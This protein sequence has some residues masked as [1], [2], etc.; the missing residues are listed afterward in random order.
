MNKK[1]KNI[2]SVIQSVAKNLGGTQWMPS[3]SLT[4]LHMTKSTLYSVL[5]TLCTVLF[6]AS[7]TDESLVD[8]P[9]AQNALRTVSVNLG[10]PADKPAFG[11]GTT[12]R[13]ALDA[14]TVEILLGDSTLAV[15][16]TSSDTYYTTSNWEDGDWL[17][18]KIEAG[19][20]QGR[21]TL[22]YHDSEERPT[23]GWHLLKYCSYFKYKG[24]TYYG[25]NDDE[26]PQGVLPIL[27][28]TESE[29]DA[30]LIDTSNPL[31]IHLDW[32]ATAPTVSLIYINPESMTWDDT[33]KLIYY[34]GATEA[35]ELWI[36]DG[37]AWT[38]PQARLRVNTGAEGDVVTLTSS[39]FDSAWE[40][41]PTVG[42]GEN[43]KTV[44]TATTDDQGNAY[45]YGAT[46]GQLT[47]D[48]LVEL[49]QMCVP[50]QTPSGSQTGGE[51]ESVSEG[52]SIE[53]DKY[54]KEFFTITLDTPITLLEASDVVPVKL[55]AT[56]AYKLMA[57][58]DKRTASVQANLSVIDGTC[59]LDDYAS[60]KTV[61][62]CKEAIKAQIE[63]AMAMGITEFTVVNQLSVWGE[64]GYNAY[65]ADVI[66]SLV[67]LDGD[68]NPTENTNVG[69]ISLVF[70]D[71]TS[72][73]G[74][75]FYA[76]H[77][78]KNVSFSKGVTINNKYNYGGT[79]A[80]SYCSA[81]ENV[82]F[83]ENSSIGIC[84][85]YSCNQLTNI[86]LNMVTSIA[87]DAF[88][89]CTFTGTVT[90]SE[91]TEV[92]DDAFYNAT[93]LNLVLPADQIANVSAYDG[94]LYWAGAEWK[95]IKVGETEYTAVGN[96]LYPVVN[97]VPVKVIGSTNYAVIDGSVGGKTEGTDDDV[98][99][100]KTQIQTA[101]GLTPK[102]DHFL[103]INGLA[104]YDDPNPVTKTIVGRA[105]RD[106]GAAEGSIILVLDETITS[107]P[108]YAFIDCE[109][110]Q[111]VTTAAT[112][113]G[114]Y[115]FNDCTSLASV[116]VPNA[117]SIG[118]NAFGYCSSLTSVSVPVA[119]TIS[120]NAFCECTSLT[121]VE[122]P[123]ATTI[124]ANAFK[125]CSLL[126]NVNLAAAETIGAEAFLSCSSLA[127]ISLPAATTIMGGAFYGC[128]S[129]A[130]LSLPAVTSIGGDAFEYCTALVS[131]EF[132]SPITTIGSLAFGTFAY[133]G[134]DEEKW[135]RRCHLT[136]HADQ[137]NQTGN[138]T[139]T[140]SNGQLTWAD[141]AWK[142]ITLSDGTK[143]TI[144]NGVPTVE[145]DGTCGIT[146]NNPTG[147]DSH[148]SAMTKKIKV[149]ANTA[150]A[151]NPTK[152]IVNTGLAKCE[153]SSKGTET[154]VGVAIGTLADG[155]ITLV[156]DETITSVPSS[157][158][159]W[160]NSLT[161]VSLPAAQTIG[162]YAF[163]KCSSLTSVS[164][165]AATSIGTQA[166]H[167]CSALTSLTFGSVVQQVGSSVFSNSNTAGCDLNLAE[168]Q[169]NPVTASGGNLMWAGAAWKSITVGDKVYTQMNGFV[170]LEKAGVTYAVLDG[171]AALNVTAG[172]LE[173]ALAT[174]TNITNF[175]VINQLAS[176]QGSARSVVGEAIRQNVDTKI[177]LML[178]DATV[179]PELAFFSCEAL[180]S[181][182]APGAYQIGNAAFESC[183]NLQS[184][185][186][187]ENAVGE[188]TIG[189]Y[190]FQNDANLGVIKFY[191]VVESV[192]NEAFNGVNHQ[193]CNL[194]LNENQT[195]GDLNGYY[196]CGVQWR[197][198]TYWP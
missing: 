9:H 80:F 191:K 41:E 51:T 182:S 185:E 138:L 115:A 153:A 69:K 44:F 98:S 60:G 76:C 176:Y 198:I 64:G 117:N 126:A 81:L 2:V 186:I 4:A 172:I 87:E 167:T 62:S 190:A 59:G 112:S 156:L 38:T 27:E 145:V 91:G 19:S 30:V 65:L 43:K 49:T 183:I 33:G 161:S 92:D 179:V 170:K 141:Y 28:I 20:T 14:Q 121:N 148:V 158:F 184:V 197:S 107:V 23:Q 105:I 93:G 134:E 3:G 94:K 147:Y 54:S 12:S 178:A 195:H 109:A 8:N 32:T 22:E 78:L 39:A 173:N 169:L 177:T 103:V 63:T 42:E 151:Q 24:D 140:A 180:Q 166:F 11:E 5:C 102:I 123:L 164:L 82:T 7:C 67:P 29:E 144:D 139:V 192:G 56:K 45:F 163:Y 18:V 111:Q 135:T 171:Q 25:Y 99:A 136:L 77:A 86:N 132:G 16:R 152:V 128:S 118:M 21:L 88:G 71:A 17:L 142:S 46:S 146:G 100:V 116:S 57:A 35:P 84:A 125:S 55:A 95:S 75:A 113:I 129:L 155:S 154:V 70:A 122:L 131:L 58:T 194:Y 89:E 181:V 96:E 101:M 188:I 52:R 168:D 31:T 133:V 47:D 53:L 90:I 10:M 150:T 79:G 149:V 162:N 97:G 1:T 165:P 66:K 124:G 13:A 85:F 34:C 108:D 196:W 61:A 36:A 110:L 68:N 127:S 74:D 119:T 37:T 157:A 106:C 137:L 72:V 175:Y 160:C 189:Q 15:S 73:P 83:A 159:Q 187:G 26:L 193:S 130:S 40:V 104:T 143:Y 48:F 120:D 50:V 6:L 114:S 174:E